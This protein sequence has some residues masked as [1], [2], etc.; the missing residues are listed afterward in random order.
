MI[1]LRN[2]VVHEYFGIN[3][4]M[5]WEIV[6]LNLPELENKIE[7]LIDNYNDTFSY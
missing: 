5:I 1:A 6:Q 4:S 3:F 7:K 2:I